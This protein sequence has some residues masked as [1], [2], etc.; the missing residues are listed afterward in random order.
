MKLD[1]FF[2]DSNNTS[3]SKIALSVFAIAYIRIFLENFS[4]TDP[5]G[6]FYSSNYIFFHFPFYF[7]SLFL[8][9]VLLTYFFSKKKLL[10]IANF[11][12]KIFLFTLIPPIADLIA[13][14]GAG[15]AVG[16]ITTEP[17]N[18]IPTFFKLINP[19][20]Y[21]GVTL[22]VHVAAY[23]ILFFFG[24][25]IFHSTKSFFKVFSFIVAMYVILFLYAISPS[26]IAMPKLH[27]TL[28]NANNAYAITM[29]TSWLKTM[30]NIYNTPLSMSDP[31]SQL[32]DNIFISPLTQ[33]F[34][35][36]ILLQLF[37]ILL[38][39]Y[40]KLIA[41]LKK[42][43]RIERIFT[44]IAIACIG[45][46]INQKLF[47]EINLFNSANLITLIT[48]FSLIILNIW[49][50]ACVN[51][52]ED[53]GIDK[54]SNP[55]RPLASAALSLDQ[56]RKIQVVLL[57]LIIL[58][59]G[60]LSRNVVFCLML[61]QASYYIYSSNPLR[62]KRHFVTSSI[63]T[64]FAAAMIAMSGFYLV[65]PDQHLRA[66][67]L[68]ALFLIAGSFALIFNVKDIKDYEGDKRNN[69]K[70]L[71]VAIGLKNSK[72]ILGF[73]CILIFLLVPLFFH[74]FTTI[75]LYLAVS[76]GMFY[77]LTKKTYN[78]KYVFFM[79]FFYL[80]STMILFG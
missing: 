34:F 48:F 66:F 8:S 14:N 4:N 43:L 49:L 39:F 6:Y 56:W 1:Q 76:I 23:L 40:P 78:D 31:Y 35:I 69:I 33:L 13:T 70:T 38:I 27:E 67:P 68:W 77:L 75:P 19:L 45:I 10:E 71:P 63:I 17:Q 16:Y 24:L 50:A 51:D 44:W 25:F 37:C 26:F 2:N 11:A 79:L 21:D 41:A 61:A 5:T 53:V 73:I 60:T 18:F 74:E 65:S 64:G 62:L 7:I 47:G 30:E 32:R 12:I 54:I 59:S 22:G 28:G 46:F 42:E 9:L 57:F 36:L 55:N 3:L 72:I 52:S 20:G 58:G 15:S 80:V 29:E